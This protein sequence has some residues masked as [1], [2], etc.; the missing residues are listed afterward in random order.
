MPKIEVNGNVATTIPVGRLDND[1]VS[2]NANIETSENIRP[3]TPVNANSEALEEITQ[4]LNLLHSTPKPLKDVNTR[5]PP[6]SPAEFSFDKETHNFVHHEPLTALE[7]VTPN[8]H[9]EGI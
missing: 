9:V 3:L 2:E 5:T 4:Q 8:Q 7:S 1:L 6:P